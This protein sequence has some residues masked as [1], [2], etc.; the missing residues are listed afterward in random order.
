LNESSGGVFDQVGHLVSLLENGEITL[1]SAIQILHELRINPWSLLGGYGAWVEVKKDWARL[2][3]IPAPWVVA[4]GPGN[5]PKRNDATCNPAESGFRVPVDLD[6]KHLPAD[7]KVKNLEVRHCPR[8]RE[9][10]PGLAVQENLS[11]H[12]CGLLEKLPRDLEVGGRLSITSCSSLREIRLGTSPRSVLLKDNFDLRALRLPPGFEG[13]LGVESCM[14]FEALSVPSG[15]LNNLVL[16]SSGGPVSLPAVQVKGVLLLEC[17]D[18]RCLPEGLQVDG[19]ARIHIYQGGTIEIPA[20]LKFGSDLILD[21]PFADRL[22]IPSNIRVKG[23]VYLP[24]VPPWG[25]EQVAPD[26]LQVIA[27]SDFP[28]LPFI[29]IWTLE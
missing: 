10:G 13:N 6:L 14:R 29:D 21:V 3:G 15:C 19:I 4:L 1:D 11:L 9:L 7:L 18:L 25:R 20:G 22:G 28:D 23:K 26:H 16:S 24:E 12:G 27:C 2:L 8:L 17:H 5:R